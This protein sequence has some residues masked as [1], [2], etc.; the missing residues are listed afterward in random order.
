MSQVRPLL[1]PLLVG[2]DDLLALADRRLAE[3]A[4]GRG[5]LLLL[6]G[7]AGIGKTRL[8]Q[9][10]LRKAAAMGFRIAKGD[11]APQDR[12]VP[13]ASIL[14]LARTMR[15]V[16]A[17]G[18][19]GEGLLATGRPRGGDELGARRIVVR[20]IAE[21]IVAAVGP[22]TVLAFEDLQWADELSLEVIAELARLVRDAPVLLVGAYRPDELPPGSIHREWRARLLG[23]RPSTTRRRR[24]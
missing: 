7:E 14:D 15:R 3:A 6:A 23:W 2:R 21:R 12:Q 22:P 13:L 9:A 16:P 24:W 10:I 5:Q 11:L 20:D 19:L 18:D 4:S 8:L 17:F 1:S